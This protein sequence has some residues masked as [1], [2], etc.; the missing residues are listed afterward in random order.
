MA[1]YAPISK[2]NLS[3]QIAQHIENLILSQELK[4]G[5]KLPGE[6]DL[7]EQYCASRNIVREAIATLK[8]R[9]LV[10]VRN[11]S[12]AYIAQP[13]SAL[14]TDVVNRLV[15]FGSA[16][17]Y[18]VYEVRMA[19]EVRACG[20]AAEHADEADINLL[21]DL[22]GKMERDYRNDD[23]WPEYDYEFHELI[24]KMT[25]ISLYQ[26]FLRPLIAIVQGIAYKNPTSIKARQSGL[27]AH[28]K[29]LAAIQT[30][31]RDQAESAMSS[32]LN[33]F[34]LDL[35]ES[36]EKGEKSE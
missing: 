9:G 29:I 7:A 23:L 20:L 18:E 12:G 31:Q 27:A 3:T 1:E 6:L 21:Q 4:V 17:A 14:L 35:V 26:A 22:L 8:V 33:G 16:T 28:K 11:G 32:H 13:D 2:S 5:D 15:I 25:G 36:I 34:L 19:L 30:R 10:D 24:A